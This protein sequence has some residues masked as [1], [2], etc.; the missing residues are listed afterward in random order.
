MKLP[1]NFTYIY[2]KYLYSQKLSNFDEILTEQTHEIT[3]F[4][5][6]IWN[7]NK[8]LLHFC[9]TTLDKCK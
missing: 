9:N 2:I 4:M 1:Y 5:R 3:A 8:L 6:G 7:T